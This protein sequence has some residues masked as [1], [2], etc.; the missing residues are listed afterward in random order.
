MKGNIAV[1]AGKIAAKISRATG[2]GNGGMIG[3]KIAMA[4]DKKL[5]QSLLPVKK[6][7]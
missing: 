4:L 1:F 2:R 6:L 5:W 7:F 3:G